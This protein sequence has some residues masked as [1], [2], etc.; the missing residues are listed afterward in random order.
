[1]IL[2]VSVGDNN[3]NDDNDA[4]DF[5]MD[6]KSNRYVCSAIKRLLRYKAGQNAMSVLFKGGSLMSK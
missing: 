5:N 4:G 1:M 3:T 2:C 6:G